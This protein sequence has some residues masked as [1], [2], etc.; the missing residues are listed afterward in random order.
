MRFI[1]IDQVSEITTLSRATIYRL[2]KK[3]EFPS[4]IK[5]AERSS[6][7]GE[8]EVLEYLNNKIQKRKAQQLLGFCH[9]VILL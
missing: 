4:Q 3:G 7:W 5:L 6:G 2:I 9:F 8:Q 1:K